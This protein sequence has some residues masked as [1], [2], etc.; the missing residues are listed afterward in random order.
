MVLHI[1]HAFLKGVGKALHQ[2]G[3]LPHKAL[4]CAVG[5]IGHITGIHAQRC[6][7][8]TGSLKLQGSGA[9]FEFN[10]KV[11]ASA[12]KCRR[13]GTKIN[14]LIDIHIRCRVQIVFLQDVF[15]DHLGHTAF[16]AAKNFLPL[17]I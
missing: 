10:G 2:F 5:C 13:C 7:Y 4:S 14:A 12:G 1:V 17:Q 11:S 8:I 16:A 6:N 9:R 15:K 3:V